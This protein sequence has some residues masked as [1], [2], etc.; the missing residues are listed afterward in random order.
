MAALLGLAA[1]ACGPDDPAPTPTGAAPKGAA[2]DSAASDSPLTVSFDIS[3]TVA[4][5]GELKTVFP[6]LGNA[7]FPKT[8]GEYVKGKD[9][10]FPLPKIFLAK[11]GTITP[12]VNVTLLDYAGPATYALR[13]V[14]RRTASGVDVN[15]LLLDPKGV[16]RL[17][18]SSTTTVTVGAD[19]GGDWTFTGLADSK[20]GTIN[21]SV[22]WKCTR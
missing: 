21:G 8:C 17:N 11:L 19:G 20:G 4:V 22:T 5:K 3:G 10:R 2:G 7:T 9:G 18:D 15:T 16:F 13:S 1:A 14:E 6:N 12:T